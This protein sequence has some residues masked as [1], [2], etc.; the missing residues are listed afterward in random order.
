MSCFVCEND[1]ITRAVV[2]M[3][4]PGSCPS[5]ESLKDLGKKL[6]ELNIRAFK[7]RYEDRQVQEDGIAV[8]EEEFELDRNAGHCSKMQ[9]LKSLQCLMYQCSE[10]DIP[11]SSL[12]YKRMEEAEN[13]LMQEIIDELPEWKTAKWG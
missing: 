10:G 7:D 2:A 12:L 5:E 1:T 9:L 3:Q 8:D 11:E 13:R 6:L 4:A